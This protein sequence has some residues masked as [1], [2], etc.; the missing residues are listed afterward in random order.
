[1]S[2]SYDVVPGNDIRSADHNL[3]RQDLLTGVRISEDKA[4]A[5]I[6][7]IDFS[8]VSKGNIKKVAVDQ[9]TT[10]RFSGITKYPTVFFV[11]FE[12]DAS[13]GH[14]ITID[15][16]GVKYPGGTAPTVSDGANDVTGLMFI[17]WGV[18]DFSCYYA[19]FDLSEPA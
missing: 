6:V 10:L 7:T 12:M 9:N 16:S 13:G 15:Q 19:G 3:L 1:M 11:E 17:C 2:N 8:D 14:V 4:G 18:N 5:S